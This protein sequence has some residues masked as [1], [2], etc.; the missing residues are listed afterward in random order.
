MPCFGEAPYSGEKRPEL[1][2]ANMLKQIS[3][4]TERHCNSYKK[5]IVWSYRALADTYEAMFHNCSKTDKTDFSGIGEFLVSNDGVASIAELTSRC[6]TMSHSFHHIDRTSSFSCK[7]PKQVCKG[8]ADEKGYPYTWCGEKNYVGAVFTCMPWLFSGT[9][10]AENGCN[11]FI[12]TLIEN[13]NRFLKRTKNFVDPGTYVGKVKDKMMYSVLDVVLAD[14]YRKSDGTI[15]HASNESD[16]NTRVWLVEYIDGDYKIEPLK[17]YHTWT[18]DMFMDLEKGDLRG[19][20]NNSFLCPDYDITNIVSGMAD[21]HKNTPWYSL[22]HAWESATGGD[23]DIKNKQDI[24]KYCKFQGQEAS[25]VH[26]NG[27][28]LDGKFATFDW[29][30]HFLFGMVQKISAFGRDVTSAAADLLSKKDNGAPESQ[31]VKRAWELGYKYQSN[32][33]G[34]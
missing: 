5:P 20:Y 12:S 17:N 6:V 23:Y 15:N 30:G 13:Q 27:V 9:G 28:I 2:P 7:Y 32:K 11:V 18:N 26:T 21:E 3:G 14:D 1:K 4:I 34:L 24:V 10:R 8:G 22:N 19:I 31:G 29:S 16:N 25:D 33:L